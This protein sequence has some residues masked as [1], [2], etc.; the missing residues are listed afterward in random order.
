MVPQ[1]AGT[2]SWGGS[3]TKRGGSKTWTHKGCKKAVSHASVRL[4]DY[5]HSLAHAYVLQTKGSMV[6]FVRKKEI[7]TRF[8]KMRMRGQT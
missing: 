5:I 7:E 2:N 4:P 1:T 8:M 6:I 3:R